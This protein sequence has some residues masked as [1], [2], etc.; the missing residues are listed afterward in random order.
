M[1]KKKAGVPERPRRSPVQKRSRETVKAILQ[2]AA[3]VLIAGGYENATTNRI[4]ERA[5]IGI[6]S[7]YHYF[8]NKEAIFAALTDHA[9]AE[10]TRYVIRR[11]GEV[12]NQ[13]SSEE[14]VRGLILV[15]VGVLQKYELF[16]RAILTEIP[17]NHQISLIHAAEE[18]VLGLVSRLDWPELEALRARKGRQFDATLFLLLNMLSAAVYRIALNKPDHVSRETLIEE[19]VQITVG[20]LK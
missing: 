2:A 12:L 19:L 17:N 9:I 8:P 7:L 14:T 3:E 16:V 5:G 11:S 6:G 4:A 1:R 20:I 18:Q 15:A 10:T 13:R